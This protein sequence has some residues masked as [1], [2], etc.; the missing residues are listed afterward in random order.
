[1]QEKVKSKKLPNEIL[2]V[3]GEEGE[4]G[5]VKCLKELEDSCNLKN[6]DKVYVYRLLSVRKYVSKSELVHI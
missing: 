3:E 6:G 1:M 5:A 2:V 4:L